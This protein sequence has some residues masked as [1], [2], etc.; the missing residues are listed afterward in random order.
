LQ[1]LRTK[2]NFSYFSINF[3]K[4]LF[5]LFSTSKKLYLLILYHKYESFLKFSKK[6][7]KVSKEVFNSIKM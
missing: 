4:L 5:D 3:F 7:C 2:K 1:K 6:F